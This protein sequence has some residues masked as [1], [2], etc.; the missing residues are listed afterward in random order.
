MSEY[1]STWKN[2]LL[3]FSLILVCYRCQ[4]A[5][6]YRWHLKR[7]SI[8]PSQFIVR[9]AIWVQVTKLYVK[10]TGSAPE[11]SRCHSACRIKIC[12]CCSYQAAILCHSYLFQIRLQ[13]T[14]ASFSFCRVCLLNFISW[15]AT[16]LC[17]LF[18]VHNQHRVSQTL[19]NRVVNNFHFYFQLGSTITYIHF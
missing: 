3:H 2:E 18:L 4:L 16:M 7:P 11:Q 13:M 1:Y 15:D 6:K 5:L 10:I 19:Y 8:L 12:E 17:L 14:F 9:T